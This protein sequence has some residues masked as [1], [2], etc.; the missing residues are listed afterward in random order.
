MSSSQ[1]PEDTAEPTPEVLGSPAP[2]A[3]PAQAVEESGDTTQATGLLP[4]AHWTQL[5]DEVGV[6]WWQSRGAEL[7]KATAEMLV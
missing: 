1:R 5:A 2:P 6:W 7:K 3:P 4:A